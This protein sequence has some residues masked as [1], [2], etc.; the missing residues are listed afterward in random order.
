LLV[1]AQAIQK[2]SPMNAVHL[3]LILTWMQNVNKHN[4]VFLDETLMNVFD[5]QAD[6]GR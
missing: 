2:L 4:I 1:V 5:A 6:K 3:L